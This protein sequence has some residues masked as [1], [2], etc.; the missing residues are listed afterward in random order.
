MSYNVSDVRTVQNTYTTEAVGGT[1]Q[2]VSSNSIY[3]DKRVENTQ[4]EDTQKTSKID[5]LLEK[6]AAEFKNLGLNVA[7]LKNS[8]ILFRITG[9]NQAEIENASENEL[10]TIFECLKTAIK[11]STKNGKVDLEK[12]GSLAN[13][14]YVAVNGGWTIEGFKK[15]NNGNKECISSRLERFFGLDKKGVK[16]SDLSQAE[17]EN[18]LQRYFDGYFKELIA[19]GKSPEEAY[20]LQ[21]QDFTKLLINT[22]DEEKGIFKQAITSLIASNRVKGLDAVLK[23][24]DTPANRTEWANSWTVEDTE[25]LALTPDVEGNYTNEEDV[26]KAVGMI[27]KNKS[28]EAIARDQAD[29]QEKAKVF[30]EENKE[31]L[32]T[33]DKKL[34]NG[35]ELTEKEQE[36]LRE[37]NNFFKAAKAGEIAGTAINEII[38]AEVKAKFLDKMNRDAYKLPI[39]KEVIE[40][41]EE[42]IENN[43]EVLTMPKEEIVKLLDNATNGNYTKVA[44]GSTETLN[45]PYTEKT[46]TANNDNNVGFKNSNNIDTTRVESLRTEIANTVL[47]EQKTEIIKVVNETPTAKENQTNFVETELKNKAFKSIEG[48]KAYL[49]ETGETTFNFATEV[50]KKYTDASTSTQK[51]AMNYFTRSSF[52]VQELFLN[53]ITNSL[54]GMVAAAKEI[55]LSKFNLIGMTTTTEKQ[56]ELIQEQRD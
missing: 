26:T 35:E 15:H 46:E 38:S 40:A 32:E 9:K 37:R 16:L 24:F 56:V 33:I 45:A 48:V 11:D 27:T 36:I 31:I 19:K 41:V 17:I 25:R 43:P 50:F 3:T 55:D 47:P 42:F 53:K 20:K 28:E 12:I 4:V 7:E 18:Y 23:S 34:A 29:L 5:E 22:P 52:A 13:D 44:S 30:F 39:Y 10:K 6:L 2:T 51:W 8:G 14:Y 54:T 49:E 1:N 21:L